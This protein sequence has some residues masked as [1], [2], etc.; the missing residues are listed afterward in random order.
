MILANTHGLFVELQAILKFDNVS[1]E[2]KIALIQKELGQHHNIEIPVDVDT[3]NI[4][5]LKGKVMSVTKTFDELGTEI[6]S[7]VVKSKKLGVLETEI[8]K[9]EETT[10][11]VAQ[12]FEEI[13]KRLGEFTGISLGDVFDIGDVEGAIHQI[14]GLEKATL[15][16]DSAINVKGQSFQRVNAFVK[17]SAGVYKQT[18]LSINKATGEVYALDRGLKTKGDTLAGIVGKVAQW[19]VGTSLIY[20]PLR[21]MR[22]SIQ[23]LRDM[24]TALTEHS[25]VL[26]ITRQDFRRMGLE[27]LT[28]ASYFGRSVQDM[29]AAQTAFAKAGFANYQD[30]A[31]I[32]LAA[33][34]AGNMTEAVASSFLIA[35]NAAFGFGGDVEKVSAL[36]DSQTQVANRHAIN[37]E[38]LAAATRYAGN[39]MMLAGETTQTMTAALT[40]M[41]VATQRSGAEI[42]RAARTIQMRLQQVR[43]AFDGL[44]ISIDGEIINAR[45]L[46]NAARALSEIG[47]EII[48]ME[49]GVE[50][51]ATMT[52][53]AEFLA[54]ALDKGTV[55]MTELRK[56]VDALAGQ[57]QSE[58]LLALIFNI[59]EYRLA[60]ENFTNAYGAAMD[61]AMISADSW[62]GRLNALNNAWTRLFASATDV[63]GLARG[64]IV[65]ATSVIESLSQIIALFST[66]PGQATLAAVAVYA[67][68]KAL[69]IPAF[70]KAKGVIVGLGQSFVL[71]SMYAKGAIK[72]TAGMSAALKIKTLS[73][74]AAT[75]AMAKLKLAMATNPIGLA[76][77]AIGVLVGGIVAWT[78][79]TNNQRKAEQE[80]ARQLAETN[81]RRR[82]ATTSFREQ[83][84]AFDELNSRRLE[85]GSSRETIAIN[86]EILSLQEQIRDTIGSQAREIDLV[87]GRYDD[88]IAQL[89]EILVER[90]RL[91]HLSARDEMLL[92]QN[93][94]TQSVGVG[95]DWWGRVARQLSRN[96]DWNWDTGL[97]HY[98]N[99]LDIE[100]QYKRLREW[101]SAL[102]DALNEG[103]NVSRA[104]TWVN[105]QLETITGAQDEF[106]A[107]LRRFEAVALELFMDE[108]ILYDVNLAQQLFNISD[109]DKSFQEYHNTI[110]Y[111]ISK[112]PEDIQRL[113]GD[114]PIEVAMRLG[115]D[116]DTEAMQI[117]ISNA[118]MRI[119]GVSGNFDTVLE[120]TIRTAQEL[121]DTLSQ[122]DINFLLNLDDAGLIRFKVALNEV[123]VSGGDATDAIAILRAEF[124]KA[125]RE[126]AFEAMLQTTREQVEL[127]QHAMEEQRA[128]G[129]LSIETYKAI[130]SSIEGYSNLLTMTNGNLSILNEETINY[131]NNL[132][133][134]AIHQGIV[135]GY[136]Q[137]MIAQFAEMY[138]VVQELTSGVDSLS[139]AYSILT[140][141]YDEFN[142]YGNLTIGTVMRLLELGDEYLALLE[143]SDG[144]IRLNTQ[145]LDEKVDAL[146]QN[147]IATEHA[148]LGEELFTIALQDS[149]GAF[150]DSQQEALNTLLRYVDLGNQA[151][152]LARAYGAAAAAVHVFNAALRDEN[153]GAMGLSAEAQAAMERAIAN[154]EQ[155]VNV[156]NNMA[157]GASNNFSRGSVPTRSSTQQANRA[158]SGT[159]VA[160]GGGRTVEPYYAE[161]AATKI[162]QARLGEIN[163]L[164]QQNNRLFNDTNDR[165]LQA[166]LLQRRLEL[167][168]EQRAVMAEI[169]N[170]NRS[171]VADGVATLGQHGINVQFNPELNTLH[172]EQ[173]AEE[174]Q[175]IL[176]NIRIGD[177]ESTNELRREL[178]SILGTIISM[179]DTNARNAAQW[180]EIGRT[181]NQISLDA[182]NLE[183][184][185][186]MDGVS[187]ELEQINFQMRMLAD[188]DF[189][190]RIELTNRQLE[191]QQS[192]VAR[193]NQQF[194]ILQRALFDGRITTEQFRT[195]TDDIT[196]SMQEAT[197]AARQYAEAVA[198]IQLNQLSQQRD[199]IMEIV[200]LTKRMIQQEVRN[201]VD[202]LNA[203]LRDIQ[204][205]QNALRDIERQLNDSLRDRNRLIG[206]QIRGLNDSLRIERERIR[207][208]QGALNDELQRQ[209]ELARE[210]QR[211]LADEL[212][213]FRELI[214]ERRRELN[215]QTEDRRFEQDLSDRQ[216]EV[217]RIQNRLMELANNDSMS[218]RAERAR[219]EEELARRQRELDNLVHDNDIRNQQRALDDE[220]ARF[221]AANQA[222]QDRIAAAL[223]AYER[224]HRDR[225]AMIDREFQE[226]ER[227]VQAEIE[228]LEQQRKAFEAM[229][230]A[231]I[232][233]L[234]RRGEEYDRQAERIR[235]Q[236]DS[237]QDRIARNGD[238]VRLAMQRIDEEGENLYKRLIAWNE[239]YGTGIRED[240]SGAWEEYLRLVDKGNETTLDHTRRIMR[241]ILDITLQIVTAQ[242]QL[243]TMPIPNMNGFTPGIRDHFE[244]MGHTVD[245]NGSTN[246]FSIDGNWFDASG[247]VNLDGRLQ[248]TYQQM[249]DLERQ[250]E[251]IPRFDTGGFIDRDMLAVV[252]KGEYV[253]TAEQTKRFGEL[254]RS[255]ITI[256]DGFNPASSIVS[257]GTRSIVAN[258]ITDAPNVTIENTFNGITSDNFEG[259]VMGAMR[260]IADDAINRYNDR[261]NNVAKALGITGRRK[262]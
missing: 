89:R 23:T 62:A 71:Y 239:R 145:A 67:F 113:L 50:T 154:A 149:N 183:F 233:D 228:N 157:R 7:V 37:L 25:K 83:I 68:S 207:E 34:A 148:R 96:T 143:F 56:I 79:A 184:S 64:F 161:I 118:L 197:V 243:A 112:L 42:G 109:A 170:I 211:Q 58:A 74:G 221:Q 76:A 132:V 39:V 114:S 225:L 235:E 232:E 194:E 21:K 190:Q 57:V 163:N 31:R 38:F 20:L 257:S 35:A 226:R 244:S 28:A 166:V 5:A 227:N 141:A 75:A 146:K 198:Q 133:N 160:S 171:A 106:T 177:T 48:R 117:E 214:A 209:R 258:N 245:W 247:F 182:I 230:N 188:S 234:H 199:A 60:M 192:I 240:I 18:A 172:F 238:L 10:R 103:Q 158:A 210:R 108:L 32:S 19:A 119:T 13:A 201:E 254:L 54:D 191:I 178:E 204:N 9:G 165:D 65:V 195:A 152:E 142:E 36:L 111:L 12:N 175:N 151:L 3:K 249:R 164:L 110:M 215:R 216:L 98:F 212:R 101:Q 41:G 203:Q 202:A 128:T 29:L 91:E 259:K 251:N 125:A 78:T 241:E 121:V 134:A 49:N 63:G 92:A 222:E 139:N 87:N 53:V 16:W 181:I 55:S 217:Q 206:D 17:E 33:Q 2:K 84:S 127:L 185:G 147:A 11:K 136:T 261:R 224:A 123:R 24:D 237:I 144:M 120:G 72:N 213:A 131:I 162:L 90:Q 116:I 248:A 6:Q 231:Q 70:L 260:N 167:L 81:R 86:E 150:R 256:G 115:F 88:Q 51:F 107:A 196:R 100:T 252:H 80:A 168:E 102:S 43:Q 218:A 22:Q 255:G 155:R 61:A 47:F 180:E 173:T 73:A 208:V 15:Q 99:A 187:R 59:D 40:A 179:N 229:I 105:T 82:E 1:A 46:S 14:Q 122:A 77:L 176:N 153:A 159:G 253:L 30:W 262:W 156:I 45:E 52:E 93:A 219:L 140:G 250:L 236:I 124:A 44:D 223:E 205:A 193:N 97:Q 137:E 69:A 8:R 126:R 104:I 94:A 246:Q 85:A 135:N 66:V 4:G 130:V 27:A 242:H 26:D 169:N 138:I 174:I 95:T 186:F 189:D 200:N 220:L 129:N